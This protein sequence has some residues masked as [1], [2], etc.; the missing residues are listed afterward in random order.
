MMPGASRSAS[1]T[2]EE[3]T[4]VGAMSITAV[5]GVMR[6]ADVHV[7]DVHARVAEQ[8]ADNTDDA[9]AIVV[10]H[11]QHVVGGRHVEGVL[12][13]GHDALLAA[14]AG[15]RARHAVAGAVERDEV[16]VIGRGGAVHLTNI[17][18]AIL[19]HLWRVHVGDR[20]VADGP[21][22]SLHRGERENA[23]VVPGD[24]TFGADLERRW[25]TTHERG[26]QTAEPFGEREERAKCLVRLGR[27]D[28]DGERHEVAG[29]RQLH[30]VGD[31]VARLVLRLAGARTE[32]RGDHDGVEPEQGRLGQRFGREHVEGC[33][34]DD[35]VADRV[36]QRRLV[37]D[38]ATGNV[39][40]AKRRLG[41]EQQIAADQT[42]GLLVLRQMDGDEV[43]LAD[44]L[45]RG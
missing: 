32:M 6:P 30:H 23:R 37:D 10:L 2:A 34:G 4:S 43:G 20:L 41:L 5:P 31:G 27:V 1:T 28:V 36:G 35:A 12:V 11:H 18:A 3:T 9:G 26:K 17:D 39:D 13:D 33:S 19:G 8:R 16:H 24:L 7:G 40:D 25:R 42:R 29:E 15:E 22:E 21:E 14:A 45:D 44:E 38:A